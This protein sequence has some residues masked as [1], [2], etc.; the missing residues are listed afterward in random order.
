MKNGNRYLTAT[1]LERY[2]IAADLSPFAPNSRQCR[3]FS[4]AERASKLLV[5][6]HSVP[7]LVTDS[8]ESLTV[9]FGRYILD[10]IEQRDSEKLRLL[11]TELDQLK[12]HKPNPDAV[13]VALFAA[14]YTL[15]CEKRTPRSS[16]VIGL[17]EQSGYFAKFKKEQRF[18]AV[19]AASKTVRREAKKLGIRLDQRAGRRSEKIN[20]H[21]SY[22]LQLVKQSLKKTAKS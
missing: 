13:R 2:C 15:S 5:D 7:R 21:G 4:K 14:S 11:A 16:D 18:Y 12:K 6:P 10:I 17:L 1:E 19:E 9:E 22:A 3:F 20:W 8:P